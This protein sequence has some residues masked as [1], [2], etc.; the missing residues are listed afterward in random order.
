[1]RSPSRIRR[2]VARRMAAVLGVAALVVGGSAGPAFAAGTGASSA[3]VQVLGAPD[4]LEPSELPQGSRYGTWQAGPVSPGLPEPEPFCTEG[5]L[6]AEGALY[7]EFQSEYDA[8]AT[9]I[10]VSLYHE[11]AA[12]LVVRE[13]ARAVEQCAERWQEQYPGGEASWRYYGELNVADGARVYGVFTSVPDGEP[14]VTMY[15][16]GRDQDTVTVVELGQMGEPREA[17]VR[18]FKRT[19]RTAVDKLLG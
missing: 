7:R 1:M 6:P 4:L 8:S 9:Q 11:D 16:V 3:P 5:V 12:R 15:A 14:T 18:A 10:V 17:P 2:A 13:A 19:A